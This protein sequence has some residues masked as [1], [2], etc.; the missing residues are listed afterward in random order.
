MTLDTEAGDRLRAHFDKIVAGAGDDPKRLF[1][2]AK[3]AA[4]LGL[5]ARAR[6]LL[7]RA[8]DRAHPHSGLRRAV[9]EQIAGSIPSWHV[10]MLQDTARNAAFDHAIAAAVNPGDRVLDIGTGSGLL[11][12]MAARAGAAE[13]IA[14]EMD[15]LLADAAARIVA[16]NGFRDRIRTIPRRSADLD[17]QRD[18]GGQVDVIVAEV[19][20]NNLLLEGVLP[21]MR[22]AARRLLRPGGR[23]VPRG[24]DI[25][26]GLC[27]WDDFRPFGMV[28][29]FDLSG[30]NP[31]L[32]A[33]R[34]IGSDHE[35]LHLRGASA[36]LFRF[37]FADPDAK[38][39]RSTRLTLESAG[40][41]VNGIAQWLRVG[42]GEATHHE[43]RPGLDHRS[44]WRVLFYPFD[45]AIATAPGDAI[46]IEASHD[47]HSVSIWR[48]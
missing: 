16:Q 13:V 31:L 44:H 21:T 37:D 19:L 5:W 25:M 7:L 15:P 30:F 8:R 39:S 28:S 26:I 27:E 47:A 46:R 42:L 10:S 12:M 1:G 43:N 3:S 17:V 33:P 29:G 36:A 22:D 41:T 32:A 48:G 35:G 14:C 6:G 9:E 24:A 4:R 11:A 38:E 2:V 20:A 40:G 23:I 18:L 34:R 45:R